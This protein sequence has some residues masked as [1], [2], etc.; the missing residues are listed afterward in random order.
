MSD[1]IDRHDAI[2]AFWKSNIELKLSDI[3]AIIDMIKYLPAVKS[4]IIRCKDCKWHRG[5][6]E[7][8]N[9]DTFGYGLDDFCSLAEPRE[10]EG[11]SE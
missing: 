4:S 11:D 5:Q 1:L 8:L 9:T 7:C 10:E 3:N 2:D 6:Y